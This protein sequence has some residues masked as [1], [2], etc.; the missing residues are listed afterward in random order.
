M[1]NIYILLPVHNRIETTRK[2]IE[3]LTRQ[4]YKNYH[5]VLI[6]DGSTDGTAEMVQMQISSVTIIK[7][8]GNWWWAGSL[9]QGY[10][11]LQSNSL[12][13]SDVVLI[14]NDDT[15]FD[16]NFLELGISLLQDRSLLLAECHDKYTDEFIDAG[17][18][19]DWAKLI[20]VSS[21]KPNCLSTRGLFLRVGDM[22]KIGG[23]HPKLL[24]H[25]GS[26]YEYTMRAH[27]LGMKLQIH[28][29]LKLWVDEK[30]TGYHNFSIWKLFSKKS[31]F[32]PI[33][34][35][36]FLFLAC[37]PKWIPLNIYRLWIEKPFKILKRKY[38]AKKSNV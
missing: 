36:S 34:W 19:I 2:F 11:W 24:P 37:P 10:D 35:T 32:S 25:Y 18:F 16:S 29:T 1:D 21:D 17:V 9:Q 28:P 8:K 12:S 13:L 26:D 15:E 20:I 3:C 22:F 6:D 23:F 30:T 31:A 38:K 7:G 27:R 33:Y 5:L 14:I 4:T